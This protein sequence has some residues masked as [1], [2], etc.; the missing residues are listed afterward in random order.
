VSTRPRPYEDSTILARNRTRRTLAL[1][2]LFLWTGLACAQGELNPAGAPRYGWHVLAPGF[3]PSPF[4]HDALSGGDINVKS[5]GLGDNCLGYAA[6]D[7]DF[8]IEL[9]GEFRRITFL[10]ASA[11]DT[12]LIINLPNGSWSCADDTNGLNPALVYYNPLPGAY[13]IWIGSYAADSHDESALYVSEAGPETL[14]TTATGPDPARD[15]LYGQANLSPGFQP[16]PFTVQIIGGG[17]NQAADYIAGESC[18]GYVAEAPDFSILVDGSFTEIWFAVYSP[19]DMMLVARAADGGWHC[20]DGHLGANPAIGFSFPPA[21]L[22]KFWLGSA[23]EGNYAAA[24]LYA[25]ETEPEESL[26]FSIDTACDGLPATS[27]QVGM[28]ARVSPT[29]AAGINLHS[30]PDTATTIIAQAAPGNSLRL[31]GGP[32]CAGAHRWWRAHVNDIGPVWLADGD[33][34][35]RWLEAQA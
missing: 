15:P 19:A 11:Q 31:V 10:V 16:A 5:L 17:R 1:I 2:A 20:S 18:H 28:R 6:G 32:V 29:A 24:I 23:D 21:G 9:S 4:I 27:L 13:R 26:E 33:A 14:P 22:Y 8:L 25:L 35:T 12:T 30:R 7:P 34:A 3:V